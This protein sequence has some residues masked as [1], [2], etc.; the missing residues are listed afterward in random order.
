[1]IRA[2]SRFAACPRPRLP[3]GRR[4]VVTT[5][6][7]T[8]SQPKAGRRRAR[9]HPSRRPR[10]LPPTRPP[11]APARP[12]RP[13]RPPEPPRRRTAGWTVDTE[14]CVDPDRANAPIEGPIS[15]GS[16]MPLS[17][18]PA[19]SAFAPINAGLQAYIDYANEND[20]VPG[21][22]L[23]LNVGDDQYDPAL[24]PGV[25][26]GLLDD[27]VHVFTGI[28]GTPNNAVGSRPPERGVCPA[29][30]G[31]VRLPRVR[32]GQRV[33]LDDR[34]RCCPTTSSRPPTPPTSPA[35]S[36]TARPSASSPAPTSSVRRTRTAFDELS[37]EFN[38]EIVDSQTIDP[39]DTA[40]ARGPADQHRRQC[41]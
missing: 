30:A 22:E 33:P 24:T 38:M 14:A 15:I 6:Q 27:G 13:R 7:R 35:S 12:T 1:M 41:P 18:G 28:V 8:A 29:D 25:V 21:R 31:R 16:S 23:T 17:G 39:A 20:L 4:R 9:K 2:S 32:R 26:N 40:P 19:A 36:Q 5:I 3:D 37:G 11:P 10:L 34:R